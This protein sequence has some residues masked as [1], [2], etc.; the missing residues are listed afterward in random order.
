MKSDIANFRNPHSSRNKFARALWNI[1]WL[2]FFR[3]T[4]S[5]MGAWRSFLLK[6]FGAKISDARLHPSVRI[7]APWRLKL[8]TH[9]YIDRDVNLYNAYGISIG[10]RV[11]ISLGSFL[12]TA[13]HDHTLK[14]FPLIGGG[15]VVGNDVW[16]AAD[17]FIAPGIKISDG[18][19]VGARA[20]VVRDVEP[21]TVVAGNPA[22]PI[23]S[24]ELAPPQGPI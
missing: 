11:V 1:A 5:F 13:S 2:L 7:W 10:D 9:V 16:I 24:R 12:C 19:V 14:E 18:A 21:W 15:I 23:K 17:A 20:V 6:L 4:P 3:P 22:K 8:G